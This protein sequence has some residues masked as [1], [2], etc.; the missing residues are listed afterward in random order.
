MH[1]WSRLHAADA[2]ANA[3]R[4]AH[5]DSRP[6]DLNPDVDTHAYPDPL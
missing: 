6:R 4:N 5:A 2:Y 3:H 1:H